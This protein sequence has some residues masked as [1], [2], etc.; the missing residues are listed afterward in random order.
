[1]FYP[2]TSPNSSKNYFS[3]F[4]FFSFTQKCFSFS[5]ASHEAPPSGYLSWSGGRSRQKKD[6]IVIVA[7]ACRLLQ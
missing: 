7:D 4:M 5:S 2:P 6:D 1:M 3:D